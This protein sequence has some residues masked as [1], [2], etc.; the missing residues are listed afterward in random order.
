[1][2]IAFIDRRPAAGLVVYILESFLGGCGFDFK[3]RYAGLRC[4]VLHLDWIAS[5]AIGLL[6]AGYSM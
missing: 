2:D 3:T 4:F 6:A 5:F 1:L